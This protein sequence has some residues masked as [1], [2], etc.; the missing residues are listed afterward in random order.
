MRKLG[1]G[2]KAPEPGPE[3][4]VELQTQMESLLDCV[5]QSE[6]AWRLMDRIDLAVAIDRQRR[7]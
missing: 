6:K 1:F 5:W 7:P 4:A 2:R 3:A